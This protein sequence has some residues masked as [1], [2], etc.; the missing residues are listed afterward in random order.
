MYPVK[1]LKTGKKLQP[2]T[3][4]VFTRKSIILFDPTELKL[5]K[6]PLLVSQYCRARCELCFSLGF[7]KPQL[8]H[9]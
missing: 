4:P 7:R 1:V 2:S 5:L 3:K 8:C 9:H 6:E